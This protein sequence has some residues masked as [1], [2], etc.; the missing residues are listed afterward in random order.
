MRETAA[1][2]KEAAEAASEPREGTEQEVHN[3]FQSNL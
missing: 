2:S 3:T 1:I